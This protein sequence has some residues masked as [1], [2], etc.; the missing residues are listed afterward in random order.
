MSAGHWVSDEFIFEVNTYERR[1][2]LKAANR[3]DF[4][5]WLR[6][7]AAMLELRVIVIKTLKEEGRN[8]KGKL[9]AQESQTPIKAERKEEATMAQRSDKRL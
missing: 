2:K 1:Y 9:R 4:N 5:M 6:G 8:K 7:F 3:A